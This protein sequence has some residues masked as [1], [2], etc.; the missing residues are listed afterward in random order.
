MRVDT[1]P[2]VFPSQIYQLLDEIS[3]LDKVVSTERLTAI[4]FDAFLTEK[5]LT[6][7]IQAI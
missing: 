4:I 6:I 2:D 1:D 3:D 7:K 5:Y